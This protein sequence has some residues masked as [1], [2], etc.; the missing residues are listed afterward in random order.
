MVVLVFVQLITLLWCKF[1]YDKPASGMLIRESSLHLPSKVGVVCILT[2]V[3]IK[4][5][6]YISQYTRLL[7][8]FGSVDF[9]TSGIQ[10]KISGIMNKKLI[11]INEAVQRRFSILLDNKNR[12]KCTLL[13]LKAKNYSIAYFF[14][15]F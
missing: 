12:A 2:G 8:N 3:K 6:Q 11:W 14:Y 13:Q 1:I 5:T 7:N 10:L 4:Y 15:H 9:W